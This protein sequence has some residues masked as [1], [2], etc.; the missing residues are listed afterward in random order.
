MLQ[1]RGEP[2]L[3]RKTLHID[4]SCELFW[5]NLDDDATS[6][7]HIFGNEDATH[8]SAELTLNA[9]GTVEGGLDSLEEL[10]HD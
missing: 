6:E 8:P 9:I 5:E 10:R 4:V 1:T 7:A 2:D 3:A